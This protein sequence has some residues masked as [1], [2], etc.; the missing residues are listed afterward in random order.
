MNVEIDN[1]SAFWNSDI[2]KRIE[3]LCQN[4][5]QYYSKDMLKAFN[6][7]KEALYELPDASSLNISYDEIDKSTDIGRICTMIFDCKEQFDELED[8]EFKDLLSIIDNKSPLTG[9][10]IRKKINEIIIEKRAID[11]QAG[12]EEELA[13]I[14][15]SSQPDM[16]RFNIVINELKRSNSKYWYLSKIADSIASSKHATIRDFAWALYNESIR[17]LLNFEKANCDTIYRKMGDLRKRKKDFISA[18]RLYFT[19][20]KE[21][22]KNLSDSYYKPSSILDPETGNSFTYLSSHSIDK[23]IGI[24]LRRL[25]KTDNI[26]E[27]Q[28]ELFQIF[29]AKGIDEVLLKLQAIIV[30]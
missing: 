20:Y 4:A 21:H 18:I 3:N 5:Q 6:L 10:W 29:L 23:S 30:K 28:K 15:K 17:D 27:L 24:C 16:T 9:R 19:A 14:S 1:L 26:S 8:N 22:Q 25:I 7:F 13:R 11:T 12:L 2:N